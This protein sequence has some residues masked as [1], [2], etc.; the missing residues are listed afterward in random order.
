LLFLPDYEPT[1]I[2]H[3]DVFGVA[4]QAFSL[5]CNKSTSDPVS[6]RYHSSPDAMPEHISFGG[7]LLNGWIERCRL[8]G[9]Q[10][11]FEKL[12]LNDTGNYICLEKAGQ[13]A[14]H[15][16]FLN[17]TGNLRPVFI[18]MIYS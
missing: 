8:D 6:W 10:L 9:D 4:G 14:R 1:V 3:P 7:P 12:E 17:V 16:T 11:I 15:V 18:S 5:T 13:G 2:N